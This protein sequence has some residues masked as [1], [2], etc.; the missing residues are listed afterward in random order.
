MQ[1]TTRDKQISSRMLQ[2]PAANDAAAGG[3]DADREY[4]DKMRGWLMTVATLFVAMAFQAMLQPPDWLKME[5]L[6][7]YKSRKQG[8]AAPAPNPTFSEFMRA[9]SYL[10]CNTVTFGIAL[11]L[12]QL[13]LSEAPSSPRRTMT[14]V[15]RMLRMLSLFLACTV[16]LGTTDS[17]VH[18]AVVCVALVV[19]AVAAV[20]VISAGKVRLRDLS[21]RLRR[22]QSI[23]HAHVA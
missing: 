18:T 5:W 13:L 21:L 12:V 16:A 3:D 15:R 10:A 19:Y 1:L 2:P 17:W 6:S 11:T 14:S 7:A 23:T 20:I 22:R 4:L 9:A 8:K